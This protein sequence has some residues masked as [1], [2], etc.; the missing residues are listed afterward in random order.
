MIIKEIISRKERN[1][2]IFEN[3]TFNVEYHCL[4]GLEEMLI[5]SKKFIYE[6]HNDVKKY[7]EFMS[8]ERLH[9]FDYDNLISGEFYFPIYY[10]GAPFQQTIILD[11]PISEIKFINTDHI[12]LHFLRGHE[13]IEMPKYKPN[14]YGVVDTLVFKNKLEAEQHLLIL[15]LKFNDWDIKTKYI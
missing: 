11:V 7:R 1:S 2:Y 12:T 3:N 5:N 13:T 14:A 4:I 10:R 15:K 6:D 8:H 9:T